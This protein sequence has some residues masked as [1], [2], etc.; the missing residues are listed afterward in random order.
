MLSCNR[1]SSVFLFRNNFGSSHH[2]AVEMNPTRNDEVAGSI[3][4]L[5][6][7]VKDLASAMRYGLG[8][9]HSS[10]LALLWVWCRLATV[11]PVRTPS[12]GTSICRGYGSKKK[13]K[14][15][16]TFIAS[17]FSDTWSQMTKK[18]KKKRLR[19]LQVLTAEEVFALFHL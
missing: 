3:P 2:G 13:D 6:Q 15:E 9:K 17:T 5:A 18:K 8:H 16:V 10:D 19:H 1:N 14:K 11:A 4:G 12:L 7:W